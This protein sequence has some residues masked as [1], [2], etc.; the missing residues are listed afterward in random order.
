MKITSETDECFQVKYQGDRITPQLVS[1][2][3]FQSS[4]G[5]QKLKVTM[6]N[7]TLIEKKIALSPDQAF[8]VY[9]I[10]KSK[11]GKYAL[12]VRLGQSQ[13]TASAQQKQADQMADFQAEHKA[14]EDARK[15]KRAEEDAKWDADRE[16]ERKR[17]KESVKIDDEDD[18]GSLLNDYDDDRKGLEGRPAEN[19]TKPTNSN[20]ENNSNASS[21]SGPAAPAKTYGTGKNSFMVQLMYHDRPIT[22]TDLT[23]TIN[24]HVLG[25]GKTDER[26]IVKMRTDYDIPSSIPIDIEGKKGQTKWNM[27]GFFLLNQP[28]EGTLLAL[29]KAVETMAE[30]MGISGSQLAS[31]WGFE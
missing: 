7:G 9:E 18:N 1:S 15:A 6:E 24:G 22:E 29:D 21:S 16:A 4:P 23:I 2:L 19:E 3:V 10:K 28:P 31:M 11:K 26:G 20:S 30:M 13:L 27:D 12:K 5:F 17:M 14:K 25:A 8:V